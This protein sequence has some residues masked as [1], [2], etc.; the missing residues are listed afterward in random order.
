M[1][2]VFEESDGKIATFV[3]DEMQKTYTAPHKNLP[4]GLEIGDIVEV[5]I[6]NNQL[7]FLKI[8]P[9]ER[10]KRE[11]RIRQKREQLLNKNT[12]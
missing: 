10:R 1:K 2:A 6:E 9:I 7:V 3:I 4:K 5:R 8:L 12:E 11:A